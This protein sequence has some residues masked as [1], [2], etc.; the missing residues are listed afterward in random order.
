MQHRRKLAFSGAPRPGWNATSQAPSTVASSVSTGSGRARAGVSAG[1]R[2]TTKT[3]SSG[4][5]RRGTT[6]R[7]LATR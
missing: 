7:P 3:A 1:L 5:R 4:E 6:V 2:K